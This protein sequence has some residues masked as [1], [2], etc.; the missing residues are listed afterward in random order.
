MAHITEPNLPIFV[1]GTLKRG[2][3]RESAWPHPPLKVETALA[4]GRLFDLGAYPA[5]TTG[6]HWI[7]GE[8]WS[9][10]PE[11][12]AKTL[13]RIDTIEGFHGHDED[14]YKRVIV[15]CRRGHPDRQDPPLVGRHLPGDST[16]SAYTYLYADHLP[17]SAEIG[18]DDAGI[19]LWT[20]RANR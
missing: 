14:L 12:L 19:C 4:A 9:F 6:P 7:Q 5:M 1:Y 2:M 16:I 17:C 11:H 20:P 15:P 18:P 13:A 8:L 3:C 10:Q